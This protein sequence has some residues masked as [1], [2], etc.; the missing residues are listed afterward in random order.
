M[1]A[2]NK[3]KI[4]WHSRRGMLELD[5]LLI[6]FATDAFDALPYPDQLLYSDLLEHEDPDLYVWLLGREPPNEARVSS[7]IQMILAHNR[8]PD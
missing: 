2:F 1:Q 5:L 6:P 8:K 7:I 3:Q 4:I